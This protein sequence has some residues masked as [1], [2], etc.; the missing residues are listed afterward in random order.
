LTGGWVRPRLD[1][2]ELVRLPPFVRGQSVTD[3]ELVLWSY[4]EFRCAEVIPLAGRGMET[5]P[6]RCTFRPCGFLQVN[7]S[8]RGQREWYEEDPEVVL[9]SADG[10]A[11]GR[12]SGPRFS[13]YVNL[14]LFEAG[15]Q[16]LD[17]RVDGKS[18]LQRRLTTRLG[19]VQFVKLDVDLP[20]HER[21]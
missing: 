2:P 4:G 18:V 16:V 10:R 13:G 19:E 9:E 14:A 17:V 21:H 20:E 7:V 15:E 6:L 11:L 8:Y 12:G 3:G 1:P 5:S